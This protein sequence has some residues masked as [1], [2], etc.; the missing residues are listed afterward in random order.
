[1]E[2]LPAVD[3]ITRVR[4]ILQNTLGIYPPTLLSVAKGRK[5]KEE[6]WRES[7]RVEVSYTDAKKMLDI[8]LKNKIKVI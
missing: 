6:F 2:N 5:M 3:S 8:L 4:R 7:M 1:M